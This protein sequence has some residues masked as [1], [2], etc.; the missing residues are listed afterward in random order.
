MENMVHFRD[1][2]EEMCQQ[3]DLYEMTAMAHDLDKM[4]FEELIVSK[5]KGP[6]ALAAAKVW[7]RAMLGELR[8]SECGIMG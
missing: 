2:V 5:G 3:L 1:L 7:T 8:V 4:T 6:T